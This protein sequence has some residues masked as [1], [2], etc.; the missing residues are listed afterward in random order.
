[1]ISLLM[2][3]N[4]G[5]SSSGKGHSVFT[6]LSQPLEGVAKAAFLSAW[7][8]QYMQDEEERLGEVYKHINKVDKDSCAKKFLCELA[9]KKGPLD[10]YE[11]LIFGH[12]DKP[13]VW[14]APSVFFNIAVKVGKEDSRSCIEVYPGC[15]W[16]LEEMANILK[17]QGINF[18]IQ[19]LES[20][21][22][23]YLL[24]GQKKTSNFS[25]ELSG[26]LLPK[27]QKPVEV[28]IARDRP[29]KLRL[30][31]TSSK[32][33]YEDGDGVREPRSQLIRNVSQQ[34]SQGQHLLEKL[35]SMQRSFL[36]Y[37][38]HSDEK[39]LDESSGD[40][41]ENIHNSLDE[42]SSSSTSTSTTSTTTTTTSTT[43]TTTSTTTSTTSTTT[44]IT[45]TTSTITTTTTPKSTTTTNSTTIQKTM[46]NHSE[47]APGSEVLSSISRQ[48]KEVE[49]YLGSLKNLHEELLAKVREV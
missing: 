42:L 45:S 21:T 27:T 12:Y 2:L 3:M 30:A 15:V 10:W 48:L 28:R 23:V 38:P 29:V 37:L 32:K 5:L 43:T 18:H 8:S 24:W 22:Q 9:R 39:V 17:K 35:R 31:K 44:T 1:M 7:G 11:K 46:P 4:V 47:I 25:A 19:G 16:N 49:E 20:D 40:S 14:S 41:T 36:V 6:S 34:L 26:H 33:S 13:V